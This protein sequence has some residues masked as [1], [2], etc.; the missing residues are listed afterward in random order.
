MHVIQTADIVG[1]LLSATVAGPVLDDRSNLPVDCGQ[2][3]FI[4]IAV[5]DV[6]Q[7][8]AATERNKPASVTSDVVNN[9]NLSYII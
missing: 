6:F 3:G 7:I 8:V 9:W 4:I 1:N 5:S 2:S